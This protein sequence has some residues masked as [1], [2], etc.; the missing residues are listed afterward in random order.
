VREVG[1]GDRPFSLRVRQFRM[2]RP[3]EE[4]DDAP[5]VLRGAVCQYSP[6]RAVGSTHACFG[7]GAAAKSGSTAPGRQSRSSRPSITSIGRGRML[8]AGCTASSKA[9]AHDHHRS[10]GNRPAW[11]AA[12]LR[13]EESA[14][15]DQGRRPQRQQP[16]PA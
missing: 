11:G 10:A 13:G 9:V 15:V 7:C 4:L 1:W 16:A 6:W 12:A 8:R 3:V 14:D 2:Q 5:Q